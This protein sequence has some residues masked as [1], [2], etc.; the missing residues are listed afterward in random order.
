VVV[1][2]GFIW[3]SQTTSYIGW[4]LGF[5]VLAGTGIAFGYSS[6][7]PAALKWYPPTKTGKIVGMVV[8]GF[9]LAS[10]YIAPLAKHLLNQWG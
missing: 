4:I 5:G 8:S 7:T 9:G 10:V 2:L 1:G 6:A 3:I